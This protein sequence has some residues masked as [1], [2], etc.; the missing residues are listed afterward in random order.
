VDSGVDDQEIGWDD[1]GDLVVPETG[2]VWTGYVE[3]SQGVEVRE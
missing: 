3:L 1:E 2:V